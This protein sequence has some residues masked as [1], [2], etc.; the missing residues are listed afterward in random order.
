MEKVIVYR[1]VGKDRKGVYMGN[2]TDL[3]GVD[4]ASSATKP[5]PCQDGLRDEIECHRFGFKS[6]SQLKKWFDADEREC[7]HSVGA[8]VKVYEVSRGRVQFGG[9]QLTFNQKKAKLLEVK[10]LKEI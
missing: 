10:S 2:A 8:H 4:N 7:L 6:I 9:K 3:A 5:S 1:I